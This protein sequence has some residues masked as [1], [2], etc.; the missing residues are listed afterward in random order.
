[1]SIEVHDGVD[2]SGGGVVFLEDHLSEIEKLTEANKRLE[3]E[4]YFG[5]KCPECNEGEVYTGASYPDDEGFRPCLFCNDGVLPNFEKYKKSLLANNG[6]YYELL[7]KI[8]HQL[9][10]ALEKAEQERDK[11]KEALKS[12]YIAVNELMCRMG[13]DGEVNTQQDVSC[14]V[15]DT[16]FELDDGVYEWER[17]EQTLT[18][19]PEEAQEET[20]DDN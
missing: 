9:E 11:Y 7:G 1:M 14:S 20:N 2:I 18:P 8:E 13:V 15:M 6:T 10:P 16:L 3:G 17:V 5:G 12:L 4:T 19:T